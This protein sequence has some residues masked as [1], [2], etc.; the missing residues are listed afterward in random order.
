M[1]CFTTLDWYIILLITSYLTLAKSVNT[2]EVKPE[3]KFIKHYD[4]YIKLEC[5]NMENY[6]E[7][8]KDIEQSIDNSK[9][10]VRTLKI[11]NCPLP[12]DNIS[13]GDMLH[14]L[15][16]IFY[17]HLLIKND[18]LNP[19]QL[20]KRQL[21]YLNTVKTLTIQIKYLTKLPE[22]LFNDITLR[23]LTTL[24]LY[25]NV[26]ELPKNIFDNLE[27]LI[28][29]NIGFNLRSIVNGQ[30][31]KL[32]SLQSLNLSNNKLK[33][34]EATIFPN[35]TSVKF[36]QL[37]SNFLSTLPSRIFAKLFKLEILKINFNEFQNLPPKLFQHTVS[38][39]Q[40][41]LT[42]NKFNI[43]QFPKDFLANLPNLQIVEIKCGLESLPDE[44]FYNST[45]IT[46]IILKHNMLSTL[47]HNLLL[48]QLNLIYLDL[49]YNHLEMIPSKL[50]TNTE[51]LRTLKVA[52]NRLKAVERLV[53][54]MLLFQI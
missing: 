39:Q 26:T 10:E 19:K 27:N 25:T 46:K 5:F 54:L 13:I 4:I 3:L 48:S 52:N 6:H 20:T 50:F 11:I 29:L 38:L 17:E 33:N 41:I 40:F 9:N 45:N 30:F 44:M 14:N 21:S 15:G 7:F 51:K 35:N 47:E 23:N 37:E 12:N 18:N 24:E 1:K 36:V 49:S 16:I 28:N 42:K 43:L 34:I 53:F 22:D 2:R 32:K 31:N 8:Q